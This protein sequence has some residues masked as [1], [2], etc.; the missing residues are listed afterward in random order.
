MKILNYLLLIVIIFLYCSCLQ[1]YNKNQEIPKRPNIVWITSEDNSKHYMKL[2]DEHGVATPN[3]ENLAKGGIV[4]TNAFSNAPV[5]SAARS[6]I[7]SGCYGP[8]LGSHFHRRLEYVIMPNGIEMFPVYLRRAGY[9]TANNAKEDYNIIKSEGVWDKSSRK[10]TWRDRKPGQP[11][12]YVHNFAV[13]HEGCLHFP[14]SDLK[15]KPTQNNPDS[16][17]VFPF[18]PNTKLFRYTNARYL[19][20]IQ[21]LDRK[22]GEI[23]AE[24]E[25]DGLLKST[26]IFYYGDHGGV[27]PGSKGYIHEVGLQVPLVVYIPPKFRHLVNIE[28]GSFEDGFVSFVDF[29]ATVLN[30]TGVEIPKGINGTPF[31]GK[32]VSKKQLSERNYT[33]S[34]VDRM[35]EKSDKVRAI[36]IGKY[37]YIRNFEPFNYDGLMNNYRYR[38]AAYR[39]WL[40]MYKD[41]KLNKYQSAFFET[42]APEAL[43]NIDNDPFELN[44]LVKKVE[45]KDTLIFMRKKLNN[46]LKQLPDISF[47][48]EYYLIKNAFYDT[49]KFGREHK[50]QLSDYIDIAN[51]AL[52]DFDDAKDKINKQLM[53]NDPFKRYWAL[54]VCSSFGVKASCFKSIIK[55]IAEKDEI[56]I[57]KVRAAEFLGITKL[58][59]PVNIMTKQL[60]NCKDPNE[61]LLICNS[62]TLM[63]DNPYNYKFNI[64]KNKLNKAVQESKDVKRRLLYF[65]HQ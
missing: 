10:A 62:I 39:E 63:R 1:S 5:C 36:R 50:K 23:V 31:L 12:F 25:K 49:D 51:L 24:L 20:R 44:N 19:D 14:E 26:I 22:V 27:L 15:N 46:Q 57:N 53:S 32:N 2:F 55:D 60:Y 34:Y 43:Y 3:I 45:L 52:L 64:N 13:T 47:Y 58:M 17:F 40:K 48:P 38:Q 35:D 16:C 41:G 61:A 11:F 9:Y 65:N 4:F 54:I 42:R 6:T 37:K 59:N 21:D 8:R 30:L 7:I 33:F 56:S 28:V 18:H 29:G